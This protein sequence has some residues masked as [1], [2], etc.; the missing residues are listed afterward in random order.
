M[1]NMVFTVL[2]L[3]TLI[4]IIFIAFVYWDTAN[5]TPFVLE[6]QGGWA[7]TFSATALIFYGYLGFDFITTLSPEAKDPAKNVPYAVK[8]SN[9]LCMVLYVLTAISLASMAPL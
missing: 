4:L 2:K 7:G 9:L 8:A 3:A 5:L 1:F 6:E